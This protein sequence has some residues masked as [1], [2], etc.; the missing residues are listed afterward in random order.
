MTFPLQSPV[1]RRHLPG[2]PPSLVGALTALG[3]DAVL[4]AVVAV[5]SLVLLAQGGLTLPGPLTRD[6]QGTRILLS[7]ATAAPLLG[8]RHRPL[9]A[10]VVVGFASAVLAVRGEAIWP[11]VGLVAG[12][13]VLVRGRPVNSP[14]SRRRLAVVFGVLGTYL[15]LGYADPFGAAHS[16]VALAAAWFAGETHRLR[17]ARISELRERADRIE[18][19]AERERFLALAEERTRIARDLHDSVAHALNVIGVRAGAA[20]L[21]QDPA[22]ALAAVAAI[23]ELSRAT[24]AEIDQV[25]GTLRSPRPA[26]DGV[27]APPGLAALDG[28]VA[29]HRA[30]GHDV[31]LAVIGGLGALASPVEHGAYR[32]VQEALT[33]AA[34]HGTGR[35]RVELARDADALRLSVTNRV[36]AGSPAPGGGH[37][38]IGMRERAHAL[39]GRVDAGPVGE[40]FRV[41]AW[42]PGA[43]R[44]P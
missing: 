37:G 9:A 16:A 5:V 25:I 35:T 10:F 24:M 23:E 31:S 1:R 2:G 41:S 34:R 43:G 18:R 26:P 29:G 30:G 36:G 32:I 27:E 3:L 22:G 12:V 33:N 4:V 19:D 21:R 8:W 13:Y 11:P 17:R 15:A 39:G 40:Q 42:L 44:R 14:W 7:I 20:R 6:L 38:L 28:L